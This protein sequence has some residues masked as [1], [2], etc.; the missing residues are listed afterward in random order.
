MHACSVETPQC[1][2]TDFERQ[3]SD[4]V[5]SKYVRAP[6]YDVEAYVSFLLSVSD[7][8]HKTS[9]HRNLPLRKIKQICSQLKR[10]NKILLIRVFGD[11][12]NC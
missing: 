3:A 2:T 12:R 6:R 5:D 9:L 11:Y 10:R 7:G 8:G 4:G 1:L